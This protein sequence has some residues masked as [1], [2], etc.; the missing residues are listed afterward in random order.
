MSKKGYE[1]GYHDARS[2]KSYTPPSVIDL[3][4]KALDPGTD[5]SFSKENSYLEGYEDGKEDRKSD[6]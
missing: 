5:P 6:K 1:R 3:L 4:S 2:G